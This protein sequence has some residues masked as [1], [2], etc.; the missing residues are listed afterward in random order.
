MLQIEVVKGACAWGLGG[1]GGGTLRVC[2]CMYGRSFSLQQ[3]LLQAESSNLVNRNRLALS[4]QLNWSNQPK[5]KSCKGLSTYSPLPR[6][7]CT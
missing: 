6:L 2:K 1:G 3:N 7:M 5:K 4:A